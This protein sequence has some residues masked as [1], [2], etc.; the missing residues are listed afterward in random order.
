ALAETS[1][2]SAPELAKKPQQL[3][4]TAD[5][6]NAL[7]D[8]QEELRKKAEEASRIAD[9]EKRQAALK[10]LA[11]EQEQLIERGRELLQKLTRERSDDA[12]RDARAALDRMEAS[13]DDLE[14]GKPSPRAQTEAVE[15][16]DSARDKLDVAAARADRQLSDEKRRKLADQVKSL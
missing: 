15:K 10:E 11:K 6:L 7:A 2:E 1:P 16:L 12:V 5:Q 4:N 3:K 9:P 14:K 13:R 8:K